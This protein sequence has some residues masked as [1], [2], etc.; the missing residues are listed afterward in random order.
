MTPPMTSPM[1]TSPMT[2]SS[3]DAAL[4]QRRLAEAYSATQLNRWAAGE[5][6]L[7][8][9]DGLSLADLKQIATT[10][11][12]LLQTG[13]LDDAAVIFK[14]LVA[15]SP[16]VSYFHTALGAIAL[17]A[18]RPEEALA[19]LDEAVRLDGKNAE[20]LVHR[21]E[22]RLRSG[23]SNEALADLRAAVA[24]D[25]RQVRQVTQRA[26]ALLEAALKV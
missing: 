1:T 18:G 13:Q 20:A 24:L 8:E 3:A 17:A 5:V 12:M 14:G 10:G 23:R 16:R 9:L 22:A 7:A 4:R 15:L 11:H 25:E 19:R 21:G 2:T 26:K 6:T